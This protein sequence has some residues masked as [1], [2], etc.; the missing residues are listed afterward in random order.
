VRASAGGR[1]F[2]PVLAQGV[3]VGTVGLWTYALDRQPSARAREVAAELEAQGWGCIW[4]PEAMNRSPFVHAA[5]L[6]GATS[7]LRVATGVAAIQARD[8]LAMACEQRTLAEAFPGRFLLGL[9]VSHAWLVQEL[10]H[11]TWRSPLAAM[12]EHLD[13]LDAAPWSA[14]SPPEW[15]DGSR[16]PRVIAALGP[17][18]LALAAERADGAHP[19]LTRPDHTAG[20]REILGPGRLLAPEQKVVL[21]TDPAEGRAVGRRELANYLRQPNYARS[22]LRQGFAEDD[23]ADGG[24]DRLVDAIV[25]HGDIEV[26][27]RRVREH[28]EAG[29]DHVALQVL[30]TEV[31]G[32]PLAQWRELAPAVLGA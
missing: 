23:L 24:S 15:A 19:Y 10:R 12:R 21:T 22:L 30:T 14:Y 17:K 3:D 4:L 11:G 25:V 16:L 2:P 5:L 9:G 29:A 27:G 26:I 20:A 6:L 32:L 31:G 1:T 8:P 18:M 7:T 13:A 28:H